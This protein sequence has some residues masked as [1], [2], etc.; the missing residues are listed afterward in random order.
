LV[1][2][3][4]WLLLVQGH[5]CPYWASHVGGSFWCGLIFRCFHECCGV[6]F[7]FCNTSYT[8]LCSCGVCSGMS[9]SLLCI[10]CMYNCS[11]GSSMVCCSTPFM[12][13]IVSC[14]GP[15]SWLLFSM[16]RAYVDFGSLFLMYLTCSWCLDLKF[17]LVCPTYAFWHVLQ[18]ILYTPL[19]SYSDVVCCVLDLRNFSVVV[20]GL[21]AMF[22]F[23]FL[24]RFVI[25]LILGL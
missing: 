19:L 15:Y 11:Y 25:A 6:R 22:M 8:G 10:V 7:A 18:L 23:V 9:S 1:V 14:M 20:A 13:V 2:Q 17:L 24:N 21:K 16:C 12:T 3:A 5:L 4:N